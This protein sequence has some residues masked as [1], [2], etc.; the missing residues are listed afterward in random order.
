MPEHDAEDDREA[1]PGEVEAHE[2]QHAAEH[3]GE[4]VRVHPEPQ[5]ELV[6]DLA[7]PLGG[8]DVVDRAD[9]YPGEAAGLPWRPWH[10]VSDVSPV[11]RFQMAKHLRPLRPCLYRQQPI[12]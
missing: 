1:R 4:D 9:L 8:R 11:A 2:D 5:G 3:D 12:G 6:A 7:V 10:E